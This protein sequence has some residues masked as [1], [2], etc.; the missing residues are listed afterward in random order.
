M[1][2]KALFETQ[3]FALLGRHLTIWMR[4]LIICELSLYDA[5]EVPKF[6]SILIY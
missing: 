6:L 3:R 5:N 4:F 2:N 1:S